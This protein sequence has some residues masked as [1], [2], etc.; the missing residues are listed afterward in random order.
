L[1]HQH[2][3]RNFYMTPQPTKITMTKV[4]WVKGNLLGFVLREQVDGPVDTALQE[5]NE[6]EW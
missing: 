5:S 1:K 3:Q 2:E 4:I 6:K